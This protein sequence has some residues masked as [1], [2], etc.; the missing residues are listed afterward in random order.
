MVKGD[1]HGSGV[2]LGKTSALKAKE[3]L[4]VVSLSSDFV[5]EALECP[6]LSSPLKLFEDPVHW[7]P[8][9]WVPPV[10]GSETRLIPPVLT[11][12]CSPPSE[13]P[14]CWGSAIRICLGDHLW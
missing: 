1:F 7:G 3:N 10:H 11:R 9:R 5:T 14:L 12:T 13:G 6:S 4:A 2:T 8:Q